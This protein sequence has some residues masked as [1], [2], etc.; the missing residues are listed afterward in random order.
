MI[1]FNQTKMGIQYYSRDFLELVRELLK[2]NEAN[3]KNKIQSIAEKL[4]TYKHTLSRVLRE[5]S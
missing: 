1:E 5:Y 4:V 2:L 3:G